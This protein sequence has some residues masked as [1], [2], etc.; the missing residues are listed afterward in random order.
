MSQQHE[1]SPALPNARQVTI[2]ALCE[3]FANDVMEVEEFERRVDAAHKASTSD[4]LKELLRDLP[5]GDLPAVAERSAA[6]PASRPNYRVT[7]AAHVDENKVV[8]AI[9][10]GAVRKGT[11][12]PARTN[13]A[14]AVM[15]GTELDFREARMPPGVTTV[16]V[17]AA[18]GG[19]DIVVPP[20][21]RVESHGIGILGGFDH[22][23]EDDE[24]EDLDAPVLRITGFACMGG[25]SISVR[26]P[27]ESTRDAR[28]RR[29][30]DRKERRRLGGG[31]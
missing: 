11:W 27:G 23:A 19:V 17:F 24:E 28:R 30:L 14:V 25:V 4:E 8:V 20:G 7:D 15:G 2:E 21:I 12:T 16:N 6:A 22:T 31:S 26:Y 1:G 9:L 13:W 10:G 18:M 29:R 5:G 3:H